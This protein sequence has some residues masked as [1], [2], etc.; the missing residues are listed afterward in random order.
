MEFKNTY[1][2][3]EDFN[4]TINTSTSTVPVS[5]LLLYL[6]NYEKM[7]Q[8]IN[9]IL[10]K[11]GCLGFDQ[12]TVEV[13]A[14]NHGSF[15]IKGRIKRVTQNQ[16][17]AAISS[18]VIGILLTKALSCD[19]TPT[20]VIN[21]YEGGEVNI[22]YEQL[23]DDKD[24]IK[25]RSNIARTAT[26]DINVSSLSISY[27]ESETRKIDI[28][29]LKS[30]IVEDLEDNNIE[31]TT[32][33]NVRLR[34]IAPVLESKPA[35]WRVSFD[36]RSFS[37]KMMDEDFL[38]KMDKQKIAFGKGDIIIADLDCVVCESED[39][40]KHPKYYIRKVYWYPQYSSNPESIKSLFENI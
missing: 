30:I 3:F 28:P 7:A 16:T 40:R 12:V 31:T 38:N 9:H 15:D 21:N 33:R 26:S 11:N 25:A 13:V 36:N 20:L 23:V 14:F 34:I 27:G 8:S 22:T 39:K 29:S 24:L 10:N 2:D 1:I 18:C 35:S 6:S 37:A 19:S 4:F 5:D 17:F 32:Y